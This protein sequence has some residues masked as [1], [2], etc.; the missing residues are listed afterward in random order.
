MKIA[1]IYD[2]ES[3]FPNFCR[4]ERKGRLQEIHIWPGAWRGRSHDIMEKL[5]SP[6]QSELSVS[7]KISSQG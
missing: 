7:G 5:E 4:E 1:E 6:E 3:G 2:A